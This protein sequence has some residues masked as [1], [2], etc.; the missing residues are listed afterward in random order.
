MSNPMARQIMIQLFVWTLVGYFL[1]RNMDNYAHLGGAAFGIPCGLL[2]EARRGKKRT[3]WMAGLAAYILVWVGV[4][5]AA[6]YPR[7]SF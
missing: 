4:V 1:I 6:C 5:A 7:H 2:L 3:F